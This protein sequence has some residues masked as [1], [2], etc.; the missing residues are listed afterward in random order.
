[1]DSPNFQKEWAA[2]R[3]R[4]EVDFS[5]DVKSEVVDFDVQIAEQR[6]LVNFEAD[7]VIG[8]VSEGP[9]YA[10]K[11]KLY[12]EAV[13]NKIKRMNEL[14]TQKENLLRKR[15]QEIRDS[16]SSKNSILVGF[17]TTLTNSGLSLNFLMFYSF[18]VLTIAGFTTLI[19]EFI[20]WTVFSYLSLIFS[21]VWDMKWQTYVK[22]T[23]IAED[24]VVENFKEQI[25]QANLAQ[26]IR[27]QYK[28]AI[29]SVK[30]F[31]NSIHENKSKNGE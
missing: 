16:P 29:N 5:D 25:R 11:K 27:T 2:E 22:A 17:F 1:M 26:R 10:A 13:A 9:K 30:G 8:G 31:V 18:F 20:I 28:K 12:D 15:E 7:N 14:K 6:N 24:A 3:Q 19:I 21:G 4:I 23:E